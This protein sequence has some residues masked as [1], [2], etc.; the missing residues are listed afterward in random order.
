M[1][2]ALFKPLS[3]F[4]EQEAEWL[5][6]PIAPKGS[7]VVEGGDGGSGKTTLTCNIIAAI[8]SGKRSALDPENVERE[9]GVVMYFAAEDSISKKLKKKLRIAGANMDNI[10]LPDF[11]NDKGGEL[12]EYK[13]GTNALA[14]IIYKYKPVLCVFDPLQAFLPPEVNMGSRNQMRNCLAPLAAIGEKT[15]TTFFIICH[16][17]KRENAYGRNRLADSADLWDIARS[18]L[19]VGISVDG[20]RYISQEKNN[21]GEFAIT[22]LF[23][24]DDPG[25]IHIVGE[26]NKRDRDF[27]QDSNRDKLITTRQDCRAWIKQ[28]L[29]SQPDYTML[30]A[31]LQNKAIEAGY[32]RKTFERA[33]TEMGKNGTKEIRNFTPGGNDGK[34]YTQLRPVMPE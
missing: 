33:K 15:G 19:I 22:K 30:S 25:V 9:P 11:A 10:I 27:M 5:I 3:D 6:E 17:N 24:I 1:N 26:T 18:V 23:T 7:V 2:D 14:N 8:S 16:T 28:E 20:T 34:W 4:E 21:Y 31:D 32:S 12:Q 13:F 29:Q